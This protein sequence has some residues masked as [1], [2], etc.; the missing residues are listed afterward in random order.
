MNFFQ[1]DGADRKESVDQIHGNEKRLWYHAQRTVNTNYPLAK[2][3]SHV[4]LE[5]LLS[6]R[7]GKAQV[8]LDTTWLVG[9][10]V[11]VLDHMLCNFTGLETA[12]VSVFVEYS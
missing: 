11:E 2:N 6:F 1:R 7:I 4:G 12:K 3:A 8:E 9:E 5:L 10:A